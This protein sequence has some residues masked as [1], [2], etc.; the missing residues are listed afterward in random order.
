MV[1]QAPLDTSG[2]IVVVNWLNITLWVVAFVF[3]I[4]C[5]WAEA[6]AAWF[7]GDD[8]MKLVVVLTFAACCA[9][10]SFGSLK[11]S[12]NRMQDRL[13]K[14]D[15]AAAGYIFTSVNREHAKMPIGNC[16]PTF[17]V[18]KVRGVYRP[19]IPTFEHGKQYNAVVT[20]QWQKKTACPVP[21]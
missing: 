15:F 5:L 10:L 2:G 21:D 8:D 3:F 7:D 4:G 6:V 20:P 9:V 11:D 19:T 18:H 1:A 12:E 17:D 14:R 13:A 16:R